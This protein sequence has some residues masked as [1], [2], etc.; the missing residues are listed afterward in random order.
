MSNTFTKPYPQT[1][2]IATA[3]CTAVCASINSDTPT[4]T[5]KLLTA[6][7]N[8]AEVNRLT[9]MPRGT[10]TAASLLLFVSLDAGTTKRLIDSVLM[11]AYTY[12]TTT[13]VTMTS[14][15]TYT[16]AAPLRLPAAAELYVATQVTTTTAADGIVFRAEYMDL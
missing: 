13:A 8:G 9:A 6:G 4:N 7:A 12:A 2:K 5:V 14:F 15:A 11:A 10:N 3:V 1:E 16:L